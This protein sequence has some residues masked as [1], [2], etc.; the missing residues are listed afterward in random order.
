MK[1]I[2]QI[3]ISTES[4]QVSILRDDASRIIAVGAPDVTSVSYN[5]HSLPAKLEIQDLGVE[6]SFGY[7]SN[8]LLTS[9]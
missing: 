3:S 8:G 6:I 7:N 9:E 2:F 5:A 4:E 1:F